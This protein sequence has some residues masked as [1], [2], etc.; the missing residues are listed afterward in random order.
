MAWLNENVKKKYGMPV[1][2]SLKEVIEAGK[3]AID[4]DKKWHPP[5]M[6]KLPN[7]KMHGLG[8][9]GVA[10]WIT[11]SLGG[12]FSNYPGISLSGNG[13]A[14]IYYRRTDT[15]QSAPT[16]YCQIVADE[17]GLRYE[18][19]KIEYKEYAFFDANPP[20]GS[21]GSTT[22]TPGLVLNARAMKKKL[23]EYALQPRPAPMPALRPRPSPFQGKTIEELDVRDGV[24]FEKANPKNKVPVQ[25]ITS[26]HTKMMMGDEGPFFVSD[27]LPEIAE[28]EKHYE[29]ARQGCFVE[30][31][32]DTETGQVEI[33]KLVHAYDVGQS[34]N[35]DVNEGQLYGGAYQGLGVSGVEAVY[36]D[37]Q[38]GVKLN[39]NLIGYPVLTILDVG[40][41]ECPI[42]ETQIGFSSYGLYG[43]S[44][45]GKGAIAAAFLVPAVY[46]AIGKWI[47][48][49]PVTPDKV[50]KAL[51]KA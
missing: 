46:N 15:G 49:T 44:E 30:V 19:V 22:N 10:C 21:S 40:Q 7:G 23:L 20:S 12:K 27:T 42:I 43:C 47:E 37:P 38:T 24:I 1:R 31:E 41:V 13:T 34:I 11:G 28:V 29:M 33:K 50:L 4:W 48:E 2:D 36:Y 51:G 39:D 6:K 9:Y 35:P 3:K 5:G 14:T 26:A 16:T 25:T 32:V 45:A 18:D 8:F 17:L